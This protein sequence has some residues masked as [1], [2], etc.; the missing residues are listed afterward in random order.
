MD[1]VDFRALHEGWDI[2]VKKAGGRDGRGAIPASLWET[3]SAMANSQGGMIILGAEECPDGFHVLG[4][5]EPE[6]VER[7][8]WNCLYDR[9]KVS[10]IR[11]YDPGSRATVR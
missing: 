10:F 7:D 3:Y 6:R 2:E 1:G 4:I 11:S 5:G 8:L 9:N